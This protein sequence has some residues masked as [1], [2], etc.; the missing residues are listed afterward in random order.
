MH[1]IETP[2]K[3]FH[4]GDGVSEL[5]TI[6]PAWWLNQV[7]SELLAVLTAAGIQPDKSQPNQLLAALNRLAVVTTGNQE[8]GGQ[9]TFT[10]Q[11]QFP[12]GIHLSANQ[13]NWN[14]GHKAYIGA[15]ADNAH[16]VFGDNTLRLHSANNRI[17]YNNHDIFHKANKPRFAEDI[18]GKPNTLS[19]YGIGNFK[20]ETFWGD[21]NTLKTDGIYSLPTAVGSSNLPVENTACHIQVIA[22]TQPG[23]CR[24]LGYPAYT[25]DVYER[26]QTSSA[27]DNW[28]AW[29]KLNSDG[30]PVGAIV[31]FPKAVR[32]PAGYLRADGTT[33][34]QNTFPDLYRALGNSNRLPDL[35]RTDIGITAWFPSDQIPTGW[36]AFDDIRTRVTKT[37]YPELYRLLTG[38]YGS[39]QNV[40]QAE[41]R[42][43]R[44]AG[45]S[46]AVGTKQ[47]DE[48]K[49][50]VHKVFSHWVN[51]P[52][53]AALGYEDHNERQ[54][55]SLVST[56][57]DENLSDNGFL[58]PRPDSK[59]ATGGDEN[60]PKAL[61]LKLCIKAADTLGEA[62]FWIKSHGETI[63]AG[64]LD[65]GTLA[66][67]L[68]DKADRDHTHIAAQIQGL[69]EKISTAVAAQ[70]TRQTIG[71]PIENEVVFPVAFA[72]GN[73]KCFVSERHSGRVTG[74]RR[75]HNWLFIRAKN[76]AAAII[77]NW[78]EG[79]CDWM[80]IGKAASGNAAS[81]PIGPEI[82]ETNEE[83]QRESGR[84]S[85]GPRNRRRRDGLLEALQD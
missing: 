32:N 2:D 84:T 51:H 8:I 50:H 34:A 82:P 48:I 55:S 61:V 25:S 14:G 18:E 10:A 24:Q 22:G 42:F 27:N 17:S 54:R 35:S 81:S 30:I 68:Q 44:N 79:S 16:I 69:D 40:P 41:D 56:W 58:T 1:P 59:M 29:K 43:I 49:R 83:P 85:T 4:D 3:T 31:S 21:L 63:N 71:G 12:S 37:A 20:V 52:H 57:T 46:L 11:T 28:S 23:W 7:Q 6:L 15:D 5:G 75:Q 45:N 66:Q 80:A 60:R 36:L 38:K 26:H 73:V 72:D 53:A 9:K 13:T 64:A 76:H 62:V 19:G 39:I 47:E 74:D 65:A 77:T 78:Y 33:F 67:N 70:F